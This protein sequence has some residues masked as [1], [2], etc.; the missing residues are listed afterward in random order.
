MVPT[1]MV[2]FSKM[3]LVI[4]DS[5]LEEMVAVAIGTEVGEDAGA[6]AAVSPCEVSGD[7]SEPPQAA[8]KAKS[9]A[10][11]T[12]TI[13]GLTTLIVLP[14]PAFL[15][16]GRQPIPNSLHLI[17]AV[18]EGGGLIGESEP[19]WVAPGLPEPVGNFRYLAQKQLGKKGHR[20]S[21]DLAGGH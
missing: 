8:T 3:K 11:R 20:G 19:I 7:T 17:A 10:I 16:G 14:S 13:S 21:L 1:E 15:S 12:A 9:V 18:G 2:R 5:R 4:S 6:L